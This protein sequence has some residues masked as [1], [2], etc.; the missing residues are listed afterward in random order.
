MAESDDGA[1]AAKRQKLSVEEQPPTESEPAKPE[2]IIKEDSSTESEPASPQSAGRPAPQIRTIPSPIRLTTIRDLPAAENVH[3][4][5][6]YDIL[7]DPLLK[8]VW[9]FN[10]LH[11][12][13]W[14]LSHLDPDVCHL[15]QLK[16]IH[17]FWKREDGVRIALEE[18]AKRHAHVQ[19]IAAY[20]PDMFGTVYACQSDE[21]LEAISVT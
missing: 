7:G 12:I 13:E 8:E 20:L 2:S 9:S 1:S 10:F 21:L 11:D 17:G 15:V 5:S 16:V 4:V 14:T 19:L 3:T 18:V 6:L